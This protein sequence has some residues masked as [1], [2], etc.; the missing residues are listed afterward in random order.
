MPGTSASRRLCLLLDAGGTPCLV[1]ALSVRQ[2]DL[3]D[4]DG[5]SVHGFLDLRDVSEL[6]GGMPEER[7]GLAVVLDLPV[8]FALRVRSVRGVVDV[9]GAELQRLPRGVSTD[10]A[11]AARGAWVLGDA[12]LLEL[13]VPSLEGL[14]AESAAAPGP[15][16]LDPVAS[17]DPPGRGLVFRA[18]GANW[19]IP[20][21]QV[22]QVVPGTR[23][24]AP[25]PGSCAGLLEHAG[26]LWPVFALGP[27]PSAPLVQGNSVILVEDQGSPLGV[28]ADEVIGIHDRFEPGEKPGAWRLAS[29]ATEILRLDLGRLF[30]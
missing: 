15:L 10:V 16:R 25:L 8:G 21:V 5:E 19:C 30:A 26:A 13:D 29:S 1:D 28:V 3:P 2:V 6:L 23:R 4:A 22:V 27:R 17:Q 11:R 12:L 18:G 9:G 14:F 20:L 24:F 7:P